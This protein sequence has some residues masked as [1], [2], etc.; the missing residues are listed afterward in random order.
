M[1]L[2][3]SHGKESGPW[4]FKIRRLAPIAEA[5]GCMVDSIDY[6]D[7][8]DPD[9][10]VERLLQSLTT[11][12]GDTILVGSSMG[13]YVSLVASA[14]LPVAGLFLIA[15]ALYMPGC[16]QQQY[17][18][19]AAHIEIVHGWSDDVIPAQ[20]SIDFAGEADCDLHLVRGDHALNTSIETVAALFQGFLHRVLQQHRG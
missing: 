2:V 3:F 17:P 6:R 10:R 1:N 16:R 15:P 11:A 19:Q 12:P 9:L 7:C 4:G 18:S 5:S 20:H 8:P 13:G 14:S